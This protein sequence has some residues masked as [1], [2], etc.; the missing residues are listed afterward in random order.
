[1]ILGPILFP[2]HF[3]KSNTVTDF[4]VTA[5]RIVFRRSTSVTEEFCISYNEYSKTVSDVVLTTHTFATMTPP[6]VHAFC[7][8]CFLLKKNEQIR[9][10]VLFVSIFRGD[11]TN[12]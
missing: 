11:D 2:F 10:P 12:S 6:Y 7:K 3:S 1:M 4:N 5:T 8:V 9:T